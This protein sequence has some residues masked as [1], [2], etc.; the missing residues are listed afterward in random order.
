MRNKYEILARQYRKDP[1]VPY[2]ILLMYYVFPPICVTK[3]RYSILQTLGDKKQVVSLKA[4]VSS[5]SFDSVVS[6]LSATDS[7]S[8]DTRGTEFVR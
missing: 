8:K 1:L 2:A 4:K 7:S 5:S 6:I 3:C